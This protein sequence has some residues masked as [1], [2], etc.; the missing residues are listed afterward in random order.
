MK[1]SG[2]GSPVFLEL[3]AGW[4]TSDADYTPYTNILSAVWPTLRHRNYTWSVV[5]G[6]KMTATS[7][8]KRESIMT[9][10]DPC[11]IPDVIKCGNTGE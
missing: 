4:Y 1:A 3:N 7:H 11:L 10:A 9:V 5:S 6:D 2:I 8:Y